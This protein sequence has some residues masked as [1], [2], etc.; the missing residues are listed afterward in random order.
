LDDRPEKPGGDTVY[1]QF[2]NVRGE[3]PTLR[4]MREPM[5]QSVAGLLKLIEVMAAFDDLFSDLGEHHFRDQVVAG[6]HRLVDIFEVFPEK[7]NRFAIARATANLV[8]WRLNLRGLRGIVWVKKP[9]SEPATCLPMA[10]GKGPD[11]YETPRQCH[12]A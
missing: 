8:T 11:R 1:A 10:P 6:K 3:N 2:Q 5:A 9:D 12:D 7:A 4:E